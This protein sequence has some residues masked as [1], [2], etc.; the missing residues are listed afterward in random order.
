MHFCFLQHWGDEVVRLVYK[1]GKKLGGHAEKPKGDAE[2][3]L[4]KLEYDPK[5]K[6][7]DEIWGAIDERYGK[8]P[9]ETLISDYV[10]RIMPGSA[11]NYKNALI[12]NSM[13][14]YMV[15]YKRIKGIFM[16][17][18]DKLKNE[19]DRSVVR[20]ERKTRMELHVLR[21]AVEGAKDLLNFKTPMPAPSESGDVE[22]YFDEYLDALHG[23]YFNADVNAGVKIP[24]WGIPILDPFF[25]PD[26]KVF[27]PEAHPN[28]KSN[29]PILGPVL[30][31]DVFKGIKYNEKVANFQGKMNTWV[32]NRLSWL[33]KK[34]GTTKKDLIEFRR[35]IARRYQLY[36]TVDRNSAIISGVDLVALEAY[37]NPPLDTV[38]KVMNESD[39]KTMRRLEI[40]QLLNPSKWENT[41]E[42]AGNAIVK[43]AKDNAS[44]KDFVKAMKKYANV[45]DFDDAVKEFND[46]LSE[47][48][49]V[50]VKETLDFIQKFNSDVHHDVLSKEKN[51]Q[52]AAL[53][54]QVS[55]QLDY[56]LSGTLIPGKDTDKMLVRFMRSN[57]NERNDILSQ[58]G[59][60]EILF[61]AIKQ[62]TEQYPQLY[63]LNFRNIPD[64]AKKLRRS[65]NI[66]KPTYHDRAAQMQALMILGNQSKVIVGKINQ[67]PKHVSKNYIK[68]IEAIKLPK[69]VKVVQM[70]L[71]FKAPAKRARFRSA[72]A[73]GG[74][75][76]RDL[77]LK[78]IK[79]LGI[80]TVVSNLAQSYSESKGEDPV[81]RLFNAL[82]GAVTNHGLLLGA[83]ATVGAHMAER[84][85][86]F[87]KYPWLSQHKR[88]GVMTA[89]KL[90]NIGVRLGEIGHK[91]VKRFLFNPSHAEWRALKRPE[92]T[93]NK[94]KELLKKKAEKAKSG[95]KPVI[96]V[97][98]IKGI[99]K[100][101]SIIATLTRGG[102]SP[103]MRYLF[104]QKFFGRTP[105]PSVNQ[106]REHCTGS[107]HI[108]SSPAPNK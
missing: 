18:S 105:K 72:L 85:P 2:P 31:S 68:E 79:L 33:L 13:G 97:A 15:F 21:S 54:M 38:G 1:G 74:F 28:E 25:H 78:A 20:L 22:D 93:G 77:G 80:V 96:T 83:A 101:D 70:G 92:M 67:T 108:S 47:L 50:G 94:I 104:Y 24:G 26:P 103:R 51:V 8:T 7:H 95:A 39:D 86:L 99:I 87:L 61:R 9:Y 56:L 98:D 11:T 73:A 17:R 66:S 19:F 35:E 75:N 40:M 89:F 53:K 57:L 71:R 84:H 46:K 41:I 23:R 102:R 63:E 49:K 30:G 69:D 106:V 52:P 82:E 5:N 3:D 91:E 14:R 43:A 34:K 60:R 48:S 107:S 59:T 88:A 81:D 55:K 37:A 32:G 100:S 36:S 90:D 64:D 42:I 16:K 58:I 44:E 27:D 62:A 4:K 29:V 65:R 10:T 45:S 12:K 6:T 76:T